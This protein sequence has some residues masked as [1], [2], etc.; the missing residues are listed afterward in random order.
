MSS[1]RFTLNKEDGANI[2]KVLAWTVASALVA[3]LIS[4]LNV[5]E[6]PVEWVWVVPVINTVLVALKKFITDHSG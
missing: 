5:V 1:K 4:L 3:A 2:L 6:F